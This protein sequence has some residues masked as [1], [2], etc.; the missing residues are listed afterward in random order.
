MWP[1]EALISG[2]HRAPIRT[3]GNLTME[4]FQGFRVFGSPEALNLEEQQ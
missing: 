3:R 2:G 1:Y 4:S